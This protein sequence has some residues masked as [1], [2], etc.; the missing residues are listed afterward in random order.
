MTSFFLK[1]IGDE[2]DRTAGLLVLSPRV[3]KFYFA[4]STILSQHLP[5]CISASSQLL[6]GL[7]V[8]LENSL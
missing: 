6:Y 5:A 8:S 3:L 7:R 1:L 2:R 4:I